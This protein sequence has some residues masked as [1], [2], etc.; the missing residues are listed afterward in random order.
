MFNPLDK[1]NL[2]LSVGQALLSTEIKSLAAIGS[3][4][5]A[6]VY[7]IY[8]TGSFVPY[9]AVSAAN[10]D[11]R[12]QWPIYV[13]KAVPAGA[14]R[15]LEN[16]DASRGSALRSRLED[17]RESI[18]QASSTLKLED[19]WFRALVVDDIWIPLGESILIHRFQPLWNQWLDGFGNHDPGKGRHSSAISPWDTLHPG[20]PWVSRLTGGPRLPR[21]KIIEQLEQAR[22]V[23][24]EPTK[25]N[26]RMTKK[27]S[28]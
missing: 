7:A 27:K 17:H 14:R 9:A 4:A 1:K 2:A 3:L 20:R 24:L 8:Y 5:G 10:R 23:V 11:K 19:F 28:R 13:G 22:A 18:K 15:G 16:L 21:E 6:G 25:S 12:F 26:A